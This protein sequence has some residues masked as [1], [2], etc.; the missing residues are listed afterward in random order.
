MNLYQQ[1]LRI[2]DIMR[3]K[4]NSVQWDSLAVFVEAVAK[5]PKVRS[6]LKILWTL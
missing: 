6:Q 5:F 3:Q 1:S 4:S 2:V